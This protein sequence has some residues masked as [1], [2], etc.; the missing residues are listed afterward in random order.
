MI[1]QHF[2]NELKHQKRDL[3]LKELKTKEEIDLLMSKNDDLLLEKS[4]KE[5]EEEISQVKEE[6]MQEKE[7][8]ANLMTWKTQLAEKNQ[9]L[10]DENKR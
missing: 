10:K 4:K 8:V 6:L 2:Q 1:I 7:K 5:F 9:Q 3:L